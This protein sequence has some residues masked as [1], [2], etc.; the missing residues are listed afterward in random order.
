MQAINNALF[1]STAKRLIE[2]KNSKG[3]LHWGLGGMPRFVSMQICARTP[4]PSTEAQAYNNLL[5]ETNIFIGKHR[6]R[7]KLNRF[8]LSLFNRFKFG[9]G[10]LCLDATSRIQKTYRTLLYL[11]HI[12]SSRLE[13]QVPA[14][15][16]AKRLE[17][18]S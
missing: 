1:G 2:E 17:Q 4:L 14:R 8:C 16:I 5:F 13:R 7:F 18:H 10:L 9:P 15:A 11:L 6:I 3:A 12:T